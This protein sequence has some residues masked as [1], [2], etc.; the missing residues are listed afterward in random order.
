V[1]KVC[2]SIQGVP[3]NFK[4]IF[5]EEYSSYDKLKFMVKWPQHIEVIANKKACAF[6]SR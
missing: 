2:I 5:R 4:T 6:I 3:A 1:K